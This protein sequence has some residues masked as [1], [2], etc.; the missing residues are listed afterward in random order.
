MEGAKEIEDDQ[1]NQGT[2]AIFGDSGRDLAQ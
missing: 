1:V 2:E